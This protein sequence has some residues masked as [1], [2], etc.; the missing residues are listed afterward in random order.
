MACWMCDRSGHSWNQ[1]WMRVALGSFTLE[2]SFHSLMEA[3]SVSAQRATSCQ[4]EL[5]M[6]V[7]MEA[8]RTTIGS[9]HAKCEI[10]HRS[11]YSNHDMMDARRSM[12]IRVRNATS[13]RLLETFT[14]DWMESSSNAFH[15]CGSK[16]SRWS[17]RGAGC[18]A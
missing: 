1:R 13:C 2:N 15:L 16:C 10:M 6:H 7:P 14:Y 17:N 3:R 11:H 4:P 8:R 9:N 5:S 18:F 12:T